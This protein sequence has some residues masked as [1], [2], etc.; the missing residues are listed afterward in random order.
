VR[1]RGF[2]AERTERAG[3]LTGPRPS[4]AALQALDCGLT[5]LRASE[6][7]RGKRP[8]RMGVRADWNSAVGAGAG[9]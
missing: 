6:R 9:L 4:D 2:A 5:G 3:L 7:R 8:E 1:L